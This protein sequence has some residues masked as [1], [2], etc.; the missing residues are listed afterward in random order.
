M[1]WLTQIIWK[2][3]PQKSGPQ[4]NQFPLFALKDDVDKKIFISLIKKQNKIPNYH[5]V[6]D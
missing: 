2:Y 5:I 4:N 3:S 6:V 1:S